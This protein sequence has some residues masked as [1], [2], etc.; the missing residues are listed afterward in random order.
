MRKKHGLAL[1]ALEKRDK[2]KKSW[3]GI[4]IFSV[5]LNLLGVG[6]IAGQ[7]LG[8]HV[9]PREGVPGIGQ[10]QQIRENP[11]DGP[12]NFAHGFLQAKELS[13]DDKR[14]VRKA[15]EQSMPDIR[16]RAV[17]IRKARRHTVQLLLQTPLNRAAYDRAVEDLARLEEAQIRQVSEA[18]ADG[19]AALPPERLAE[20]QAKIRASI[21]ERRPPSNQRARPPENPPRD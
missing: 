5:A 3:Y 9:P 13:P 20:I 10:R 18:M 19:L 8:R 1:K 6:F 11:L 15:L 4:L 17:A 21:K 7:L 14:I 2:M 16:R 12:L